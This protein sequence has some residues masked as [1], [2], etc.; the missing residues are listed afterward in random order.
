V[1]IRT[2]CGSSSRA[3]QL[4]VR[5]LLVTFDPHPLEVE[6][7]G[8]PATAHRWRRKLEVLAESGVTMWRC[9]PFTPALAVY[10]AER[11]VDEILLGRF[12]MHD[13]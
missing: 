3:R 4:E 12:R 7:G 6:S 8:R 13:S 11:F 1:D 10:S 9:S 5:S 2:C